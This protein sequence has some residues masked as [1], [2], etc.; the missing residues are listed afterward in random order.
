MPNDFDLD[1]RL[2]DHVRT[3]WFPGSDTSKPRADHTDLCTDVCT[4]ECTA[5]GG[6]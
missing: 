5:G 2:E 6:C 4:F 3:E 1:A